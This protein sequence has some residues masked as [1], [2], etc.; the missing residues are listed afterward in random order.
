MPN[1]PPASRQFSRW[2]GVADSRRGY[3]AR[4]TE[5]VRPS[6]RSTI[7]ASSVN[8]TP[9]TRS[10]GLTPE[11]L[12][13]CL[14]QPRFVLFHQP[15]NA[16]QFDC[17]ETKIT[18]E[19]DWDQPELCRL[20]VSI[21]VYV[22]RLIQVVTDEVHTVWA[23]TNNGRHASSHDISIRLTLGFTG[24]RRPSGASGC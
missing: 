1:P 5:I 23:A 9:L 8:R 13:P 7:K 14:Q 3:Q 15:L 2:D 10:P 19:G 11:V 20:I 16:P 4:G 18:C 22:W 6:K 21:Y 12:I 17:T 24:G